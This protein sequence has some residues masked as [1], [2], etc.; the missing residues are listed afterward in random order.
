MKLDWIPL[1]FNRLKTRLMVGIV[2]VLALLIGLFVYDFTRRNTR[3]LHNQHLEHAGTIGATLAVSAAGWLSARDL[4]GM[5]ELVD[6]EKRQADLLHAML[7]DSSGKVLAHTDRSR[8]G[9]YV[10]DLPDDPAGFGR[11][12]SDGVDVCSP[13]RLAGRNVGWVRLGLS[14][15]SVNNAV[16]EETRHGLI[17]ALVAICVGALIAGMMAQL[18][19]RQIDSL[20]N[21][22]ASVRAGAQNVRAPEL[23]RDEV[24]LLGKDLNAMLDVLATRDATIRDASAYARRLLEASLDPLFTISREGLITDVNSATEHALGWPRYRLIGSAFADYFTD[25]EAARR[26][27]QE[28]YAREWVLDYPLTI[29]HKGGALVPVNFHASVYHNAAGAVSGLFAAAR[30][31]SEH[32]RLLAQAQADAQTRA[33]L[34]REVNHRVTNN[35]A[36]LLGLISHEQEHLAEDRRAAASPVLDRLTQ[37]L[38]G[39]MF[40]HRMLSDA[41]WSPVRIDQLARGVIGAAMSAAPVVPALDI[42]PSEER[43]SPR[44]ASALAMVFNELATNTVK[45]GCTRPSPAVHCT[46]ETVSGDTVCIAYTDNGAGFAPEVLAG[47]RGNVGLKLMRLLVEQSLRGTL[48]LLNDRGARVEMTLRLEERHRT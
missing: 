38:R 15:Q 26:G 5:Q 43:I 36:S 1:L 3:V 32:H 27:Y 11:L 12:T 47:Q 23:G 19:T 28:A 33:H 13:V 34:L 30:D 6:V 48:L 9:Q 44:Q 8:I 24:G 14:L 40:V 31:M 7:I 2:G 45:Y 46:I 35:L 42:S 39:L 37:R 21:V 10:Q 4:A 16:A 20:R 22:L 29:R 18:L 17:Y 41:Q 25:P